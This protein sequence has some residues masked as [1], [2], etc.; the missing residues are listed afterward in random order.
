MAIKYTFFS[1]LKI[2]NYLWVI[3]A[4]VEERVVPLIHCLMIGPK[5]ENYVYVL[6]IIKKE[7]Q[8]IV[9]GEQ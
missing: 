2:F 9:L 8:T 6:N 5:Q 4:E 1:F 3:H 7:I